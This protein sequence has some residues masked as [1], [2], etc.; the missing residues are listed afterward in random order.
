MLNI[1]GDLR[2]IGVVKNAAKNSTIVAKPRG[3]H[4]SVTVTLTL[5]TSSDS[6]VSDS[7]TVSR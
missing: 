4:R 5:A 7:V 1:D 3:E 2:S 6:V